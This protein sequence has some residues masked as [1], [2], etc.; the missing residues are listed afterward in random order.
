MDCDVKLAAQKRSR[1]PCMILSLRGHPLTRRANSREL[2]KREKCE[3]NALSTMVQLYLSLLGAL[4]GIALLWLAGLFVWADLGLLLVACLFFDRSRVERWNRPAARIQEDKDMQALTP[5]R[6]QAIAETARSKE[7]D[8][9]L[10]KFLASC[11]TISYDLLKSLML[12][13]V[14]D[15]KL[16]QKKLEDKEFRGVRREFLR[17]MCKKLTHPLYGIGSSS[18]G[19]EEE[20]FRGF[21]IVDWFS[22][23]LS[24]QRSHAVEIG[25]ALHGA[26]V[27]VALRRMYKSGVRKNIRFGDKMRH[28]KIDYAAIDPG[29]PEE[30]TALKARRLGAGGGVNE[31]KLAPM[32][33]N[34]DE[35]RASPLVS[36]RKVKEARGAVSTTTLMHSSADLDVLHM[37]MGDEGW[38]YIFAASVTKQCAGFDR[39]ISGALIYLFYFLNQISNLI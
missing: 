5:L 14:S 25:Q 30:R 37:S 38:N 9:T 24:L 18:S 36:L 31:L 27:L 10:Q 16:L 22:S 33:K 3:K 11:K 4:V 29:W 26:G 13:D 2:G 19:G 17:N 35:K 39:S 21:E 28:W 34:Y 15:T 12:V 32:G 6:L 1:R 7:E 23:N 8:V 20:K